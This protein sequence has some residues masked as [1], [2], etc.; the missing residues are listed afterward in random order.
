MEC[1]DEMTYE[2]KGYCAQMRLQRWEICRAKQN[3]PKWNSKK[4]K[5]VESKEILQKLNLNDA[6]YDLIG[7]CAK[8]LFSS[9][10]NWGNSKKEFMIESTVMV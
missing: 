5:L 2:G 8:F 9:V 6:C 10:K 1:K 7:N 4:R 3:L